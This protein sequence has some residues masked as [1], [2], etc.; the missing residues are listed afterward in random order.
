[1]ELL[2]ETYGYTYIK[3]L[4]VIQNLQALSKT[5]EKNIK[6]QACE[7]DKVV[8][9]NEGDDAKCFCFFYDIM[10]VRLGLRLSLYLFK[11]EILIVM[12]ADPAQHHPNSW[13]FV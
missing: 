3:K 6:I 4:K 12:N 8:C 10:L 1:M 9:K 2:R 11:K 13:A 5:K 7:S